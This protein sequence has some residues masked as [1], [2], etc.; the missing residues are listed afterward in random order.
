MNRTRWLWIFAL[1]MCGVSNVWAG[2]APENVAVVINGDSW[3]SQTVANEYVRLRGI[4]AANVVTVS[5]LPSFE[6]LSVEDFRQRLLIPVL[7]T[8]DERGLSP[9]IDAVVY[10][11]DI[12]TA[13][14]VSGDIGSQKLQ[15]TFTPVAS[16]N[17]LTFLYQ[18]VLAKDIRYLDL[19]A[20]FYA[21]RVVAS[22]TD[23]PWS[24]IEQS[25]YADV[26]KRLQEHAQQQRQRKADQPVTDTEKVAT[27]TLLK[28]VVA[29]FDELKGSHPQ[30][31]DLHYNRACGLSLLGQGDDAMAALKEAVK[32]GWWDHRHTARDEDLKSLRDRGDFKALL[33]EMKS[34]EFD[35]QPSIGFRASVGWL[36]NGTPVAA[37]GAR[38][39]L[40]S[41]VLACTSGRGTS[42]EEAVAQLRRSAEAD[43][44]RPSGTIYF[45]RN[46]DIRSTTREWAFR[47]A[48][49]KLESLGIKA[50]IEAGVLPQQKTDV[51]GAVIGISDFQWEK[52]GSTILP[53]AIVEH[54]TSFGG[55]M[56]A[57][58][59][60]TPLTEFLRHGAAG[61]SGTVTEPFA[62]QA[63]F[64]SPFIHVHYASGC[65]LAESFYQSVTGPY[66]LLIVG[67]PLCQP[68]RK[69][70]EVSVEGLSNDAA[71]RGELTL[72][73]KA[74]SADN[75]AVGVFELYVDGKRVDGVEAGQPLTWDTRKHPDGDHEVVVLARGMDAVQS[76]ARQQTTVTIRNTDRDQSLTVEKLPEQI[77]WDKPL[78]LEVSL[79]GASEIVVL[80]HDQPIARIEGEKGS[81]TIDPK[82]LGSGPVR[83]IPQTRFP[84]TSTVFVRGTSL[85]TNIA[86]PPSL[87]A[88]A[89]PADQQLA[90]GWQVLVTD[91]SPVVIAKGTA[92][93]LQESGV[94]PDAAVIVEAWFEA[95]DAGVHQFQLQ[96]NVAVKRLV[97]DDATQ[98]WPRA[99]PW[100]HVPVALEKGWHRL[101]L[102]LTGA[103][104]PTL[105]IRFG[106]RGTQRIEPSR[107]RHLMAR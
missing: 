61:S 54:L 1:A 49:R 68:W 21:R 45:L 22:S 99:L 5:G 64:P 51:A 81:I 84:G 35:I 9:Q 100:W 23:M 31:S 29:T 36:P 38:K 25:K 43:G 47:N 37:E 79:A 62:I 32:A 44:S 66:Q 72:H 80:R 57:G 4:P 15:R 42:V 102:E 89:F 10:S 20:N 88:I 26:L 27:D 73:P 67:D 69:Q 30:S 55:I 77:T 70:F 28:E 24:L 40:L 94:T 86:P 50:V 105:E 91:K 12:P 63:K 96:G 16:V 103:E 104:K 53:G 59:G 8:L 97:V 13:I 95:L 33:D 107:F 48:A 90:D 74:T 106:Y 82:T 98:D 93:W 76:I 19:N 78:T 41:T 6:Q 11:A 14:D 2:E 101:R 56:T 65:N 71:A 87:S 92:E 18:L 46:G 7:Q 83:L 52:S 39:Y 17:G 85:M 58:A 75:I 60:Q 34:V 3:A